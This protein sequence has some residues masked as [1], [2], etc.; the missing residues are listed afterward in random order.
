MDCVN[1]LQGEI[2]HVPGVAWSPHGQRLASS[3]FYSH[4]LFTSGIL[5]A[6]NMCKY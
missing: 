2:V 5:L 6:G 3:G 1:L 4:L